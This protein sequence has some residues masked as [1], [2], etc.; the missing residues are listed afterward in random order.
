MNWMS[1]DLFTFDIF[2]AE[3]IVN[4]LEMRFLFV[5]NEFLWIDVIMSIMLLMNDTKTFS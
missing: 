5:P 3:R 4:D 1:R 2:L